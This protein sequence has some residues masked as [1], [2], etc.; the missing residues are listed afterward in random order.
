MTQTRKKIARCNLTITMKI[1][2]I[3]QK[4]DILYYFQK[5]FKREYNMSFKIVASFGVSVVEFCVILPYINH[6]IIDV[7][8]TV[9]L[10][11]QNKRSEHYNV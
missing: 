5:C 4:Y 9:F 10:I 2:S 8:F 1:N 6:V 11:G 7:S 3:G